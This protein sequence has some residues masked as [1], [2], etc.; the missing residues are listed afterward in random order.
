MVPL[1]SGKV[2]DSVHKPSS[3]SQ[4]ARH[5]ITANGTPPRAKSATVWL[6][7]PTFLRP[8]SGDCQLVVRDTSVAK[9]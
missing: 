3:V 5:K 8:S 9:S 2:G 7:M 1:R 4:W 6:W